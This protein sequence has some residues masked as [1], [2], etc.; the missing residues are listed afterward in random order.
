MI[1]CLLDPTPGLCHLSS[2]D[3]NL[4]PLTLR[5]DPPSHLRPPPNDKA[6][7]RTSV[8]TPKSGWERGG[9]TDRMQEDDEDLDDQTEKWEDPDR[10]VSFTDH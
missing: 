3:S 6:A 1:K 5:L 4:P 7:P 10:F 9:S 8:Q 2:S